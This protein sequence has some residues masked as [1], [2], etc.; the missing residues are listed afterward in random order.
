MRTLIVI[1]LGIVFLYA[2]GCLLVELYYWWRT[3]GL[4]RKID[5][6]LRNRPT[7]WIE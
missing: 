1:V 4:D 3:T 5:R 6:W 7:D 2:V